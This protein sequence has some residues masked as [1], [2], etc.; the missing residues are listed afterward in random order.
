MTRRSFGAPAAAPSVP[1][2]SSTDLG[3]TA[4]LVAHS[5]QHGELATLAA[6]AERGVR[7]SAPRQAVTVV[8]AQGRRVVV[9]TAD[10]ERERDRIEMQQWDES[11]RQRALEDERARSG[12]KRAFRE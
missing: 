1:V 11:R 5:A 8:E 9:T 12:R 4:G 10:L 6:V 2:A 3:T 7:P